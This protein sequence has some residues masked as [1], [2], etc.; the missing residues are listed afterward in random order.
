MDTAAQ[1]SHQRWRS[2][3][4]LGNQRATYPGASA[5]EDEAGNSAL[6]S[7]HSGGPP[8]VY[9][10]M[11]STSLS[12]P[13]NVPGAHTAS[14]PT[15]SRLRTQA[16]QRLSSPEADV[17]RVFATPGGA[18][19]R[20]EEAHPEHSMQQRASA[21]QRVSTDRRPARPAFTTYGRPPGPGPTTSTQG[22]VLD[23]LDGV[24]MLHQPTN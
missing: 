2:A 24:C 19:P 20:A 8:A 16:A 11:P 3:A 12:A 23:R 22:N 5:F 1:S 21:Q 13:G 17:P 6:A 15:T 7:E 4:Q 9:N 14:R 18:A 10:M